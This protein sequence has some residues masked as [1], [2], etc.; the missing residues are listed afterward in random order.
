VKRL[1]LTMLIDAYSRGIVG[2]ALLYEPPCLESIQSALW[3]GIWPKR[4]QRRYGIEEEWVC[5]GIRRG[6]VVG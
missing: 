2:M 6:T 5:Y 1:W 4:T 3:H